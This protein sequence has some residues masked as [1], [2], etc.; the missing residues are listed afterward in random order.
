MPYVRVAV[1]FD[2]FVVEAVGAGQGGGLVVASEQNE[3]RGLNAF[4][5][6]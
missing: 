5:D 4:E 2:D 3:A 6:K 1:F